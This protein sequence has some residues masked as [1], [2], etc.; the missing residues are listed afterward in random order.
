MFRHNQHFQYFH[1]WFYAVL[2][3]GY[4]SVGASVIQKVSAPGHQEVQLNNA[5]T[6]S[7]TNSFFISF[8]SEVEESD[9]SEHDEGI[10][11]PFHA[12]QHSSIWETQETAAIKSFQSLILRIELRAL[13]LLFRNLKIPS[14]ELY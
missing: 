7:N 11:F 13:Y 5:H 4:I 1:Y 8:L 12:T 10:P 9:H 6:G 2:L 3:A 14:V